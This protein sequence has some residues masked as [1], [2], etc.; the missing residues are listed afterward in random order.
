MPTPLRDSKLYLAVKA[1][2]PL[3][4]VVTDDLPHLHEDL[5]AAC[6]LPTARVRAPP[7]VEELRAAPKNIKIPRSVYFTTNQVAHAS[8]GKFE[9]HGETV[10]L[11]GIG[12]PHT[13]ASM[14]FDVGNLPFNNERFDADAKS[15]PMAEGFSLD[16]LKKALTGLTTLEAVR[17]AKM[18]AARHDVVSEAT[19]KETRQWLYGMQR[20][21]V[22]L[23]LDLPVY[24]PPDQLTEWLKDNAAYFTGENVP[25]RLVPRGL[26]FDGPPGTGKTTA[27][28]YLARE[29]KVPLYRLDLAGALDK[30]IGVSE[31]RV[32]DALAQA[33]RDSPCV[34]LIDEAEKIFT[35]GDDD[36]VPAR[37]MSQLLWWLQE[38][39]GRVLTVMTTNAKDKLPPELYREG[40]I[41]AVVHLGYLSH[42]EALELGKQV[43][44]SFGPPDAKLKPSH[45]GLIEKG[46]MQDLAKGTLTPAS[47]T[48]VVIRLVKQN[49]WA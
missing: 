24:A 43:L 6:D 41:D 32:A 42:G 4:H 5:A 11:V 21:L 20:G 10:I 12:S 22:Q 38:R 19:V 9:A 33:D 44:L 48:E 13:Q 15:V 17:V 40:R 7:P 3:I 30:Y 26:L 27:A 49:H 18:A 25:P 8:M 39:K 31:Q 45:A 36:A 35:Y 1:G 29:L 23:S 2:L 34:L 28:K 14:A 47:V 46:L 37:I 16:A